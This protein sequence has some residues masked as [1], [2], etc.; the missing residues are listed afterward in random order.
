LDLLAISEGKKKVSKSKNVRP[1]HLDNK[2]ASDTTF[3][4]SVNKPTD[5]SRRKEPAQQL[6]A[7]E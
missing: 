7:E 3:L 1:A 6:S 5:N 4:T 2:H